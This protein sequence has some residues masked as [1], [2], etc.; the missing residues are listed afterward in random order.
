MTVRRREPR[1]AE[2]EFAALYAAHDRLLEAAGTLDTGDLVLHA[3]RLLRERPHVR[4]RLAQRHRHVLVDE[5][6]DVGFAQHLLLRLLTADHGN[7]CVAGDDDQA[8]HRFR[9]AATKNLLDVQAEPG[10][11]TVVRL[12]ASHRCAPAIV[13]AARAVVEPNPDRI[14]KPLAAA[15][16]HGPGEVRFWQAANERAQAQAVAADVERL[17]TR[18][19]VAPEDVCVIVR[20]VKNEG[21]AVAVALEERAVPYRIV[22]AAAFFQR[23]EVRDL[24]AWL[25]LLVVFSSGGTIRHDTR[26]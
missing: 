5:F 10:G 25:R 4:A 21:Q 15:T 20:S 8:I 1:R 19:D 13:T 12:D 11:A 22:G 3:F 23:A 14:E 26:N 18:E 16:G 9:A 2:R 7:L 17:I 6:E 24:L